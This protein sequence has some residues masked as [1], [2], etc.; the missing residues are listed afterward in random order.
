[1]RADDIGLIAKIDPLICKYAYS[2]SKGRHS[3]G[4]LDLVRQ[5]MRRLAKLLQYAQKENGE[6]NKLI[7]ILRPCHFQLIIAGVNKMAQYKTESYDSP[8]LEI[9]FGTLIK[10]CCYLAYVDLLQV[11]DTNEQRKDIKILKKLT[12]SQWADEVSAKAITNLNQNKWN[13]E[14]LL[15]LTSDLKK[16]SEF[17]QKTSEKAFHDLNANKNDLSA[18]TTLKDVLYTQIILLNRRRPAE[19]AQLKVRTFRSIDLENQKNS[20]FE[21]CLTQTEKIFLV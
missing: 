19:V 16:L 12:E 7:D 20:E 11:T 18:Y 5:N 2:Y 4:N 8:T 14:E 3:K 13:K 10:K 6:I 21:E 9:N 1:M 15:P 17:L